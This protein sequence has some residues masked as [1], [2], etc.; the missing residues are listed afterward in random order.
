MGGGGVGDKHGVGG[1][2]GITGA[3]IGEGCTG[4]EHAGVGG[5]CEEVSTGNAD[6]GVGVGAG[7]EVGGRGVRAG[8]GRVRGE[9][10]RSPSSPPSLGS[11][12]SHR[13]LAAFLV[14]MAGGGEGFGE[15]PGKCSG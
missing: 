6:S 1:V 10:R 7:G 5:P 2:K 15:E 12:A 3:A 14:R 8:E 13:L 11:S 9:R 4:E